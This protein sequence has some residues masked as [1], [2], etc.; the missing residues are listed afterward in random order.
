M[1]QAPADPFPGTTE[2]RPPLILDISWDAGP[3][4][5]PHTQPGWAEALHQGQSWL[6]HVKTL[7]RTQEAKEASTLH[8]KARLKQCEAALQQTQ[9]EADHRQASMHKKN[10]ALQHECQGL[11]H[12]LQGAHAYIRQAE[13]NLAIMNERY[14][15]TAKTCRYYYECNEIANLTL[16][17]SDQTIRELQSTNPTP[18][19]SVTATKGCQISM[20]DSTNVT[21]G[22]H[23]GATVMI[24]TYQQQIYEGAVK[25]VKRL[26]VTQAGHDKEC[27][28]ARDRGR[29]DMS[30]ALATATAAYT[31]LQG[32]AARA[33]TA[34]V[35]LTAERTTLLRQTHAQ[36]RELAHATTAG[37]LLADHH[38]NSYG[39]VVGEMASL[40]ALG[41][42]AEDYPP[43]RSYE[44]FLAIAKEQDPS[45]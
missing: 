2:P 6:D 22:P 5:P 30:R 8:L 32:E 31:T 3:E 19:R 21:P 42:T 43:A 27:Q 17:A 39:Q 4:S 11:A 33:Q 40:A 7:A 26:A 34:L 14:N 38:T 37:R 36:G 23:A 20:V 25:N 29:Q 45:V 16:V 41:V 9:A 15:E 28:D 24:T 35:S 44:H 18:P 12:D 1:D 13:D 10:L